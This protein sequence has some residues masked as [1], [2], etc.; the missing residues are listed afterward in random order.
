LGEVLKYCLQGKKDGS[1]YL[2]G[3]LFLVIAV[4]TAYAENIPVQQKFTNSLGM[5]MIRIEPGSFMMGRDKGGDHDESPAHQVT[6][7][8]PFYLSETEISIEQ[9]RLFDPDYPGYEDYAP[10]AAAISW[11]DAVAFCKWLSAKEGRAY[12][13]PTEAEWEYTCR[14][15]T[16]TPFY[17]GEKPPEHETQNPWGLKNMHT[18]VSE[19][20]FDWHGPYSSEHKTDPAGPPQGWVKVLR[21][22]G[23]DFFKRHDPYYVRSA[24]RAAVAP[25]YGSP[26]TT[27][28]VDNLN[29]IGMVASFSKLKK[30]NML[31]C[32]ATGFRIVTSLT[33]PILPTEFEKP[34]LMR[35]V[36]QKSVLLEQGPEPSQPYYKVRR[37]FPH[38]LDIHRV[39]WKIGI[40]PGIYSLHHN[41]ALTQ[42]DNGDLLAF[43]YNRPTGIGEREP[44]LSIAGLRLRYGAEQWDMPSPWPDFLDANDE[45]PLVWN[46]NGMLWLFWGCPRIKE[47]TP[48]QWTTS[49]DNGESW[50]PIRF[51]VFE[52]KVGSYSAQPITSVFRAGDGTIF[53]GVDGSGS[54]SVLFASRNNARTWID[55]VGRTK[56]RHS[57]FV[58]LDE[59]TILAYGGK[60]YEID[61]FMPLNISRD[62][63]RTWEV[64]RSQVAKIGGGQRPSL[65]K[66]KSGRLLYTADLWAEGEGPD[67]L[68]KAHLLPK[69]YKG[70]GG[71]VGLSD[72]NGQTWF[73]R[74]LT[75]G[76]MLDPNVTEAG[77]HSVG[78]VMACQSADGLIHIITTTELHIT[79]NESW[80]RQGGKR[81][82]NTGTVSIKPETLKQYVEKYPDGSVKVRWNAGI[83]ED[84]RYLLDGKETWY[85][86]TGQKQWEVTY[87]AGKKV[88]Q[89]TYRDR[90]G[91]TKYRWLHKSNGISTWQVF[92]KNE[93]QRVESV[94]KG[95]KYISHN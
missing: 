74:K 35:C 95:R 11:H 45:A 21:G 88:G 40:E 41:A 61:G 52:S 39:G 27:Y 64:S 10:Y 53:I 54:S 55:T 37:L 62:R 50:E 94:W 26:L 42:C 6:I 85:Y 77:V 84:G 17:T 59:N 49:S 36:K 4:T 15:G 28:K 65:I 58:L 47:V 93:R 83:G 68:P 14:A 46:D 73:V 19:W 12:R 75:D 30:T 51:P 86:P 25:G 24:N 57:A 3:I 79:L 43:Y 31:A 9:F 44:N 34:V 92:D 38:G 90:Q 16:T 2:I 67:P 80:I 20:C 13:L 69:G 48:F 71:Y 22:G 91:L 76:G 89:E 29:E 5:N 7:S 60:N 33:T 8:K 81:P 23:L 32:H 63:A 66:L 82:K 56:G 78:Y 18:G 87:K 72:D 1:S 70:R